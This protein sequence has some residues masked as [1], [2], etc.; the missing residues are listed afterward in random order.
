MI[1]H[2]I[3]LGQINAAGLL[4]TLDRRQKYIVGRASPSDIVIRHKTVSRTHAE[5][6]MCTPGIAITDMGS[7]NGTFV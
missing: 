4:F 2:L 3:L 1:N 6:T 7:R 5:L